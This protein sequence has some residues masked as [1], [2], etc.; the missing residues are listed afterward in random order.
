MK[1]ILLQDVAKLGHRYEVVEV[2]NGRALNML[3]PKGLAEAATENN[4]KRVKSASEKVASLRESADKEFAEIIAKLEGEA[5]TVQVKANEKGH[6]FEALKE[7][8]VAAVL[9][10]MGAAVS[11]THVLIAEPIKELGEY[12]IALSNGGDRHGVKLVVVAA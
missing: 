8:S 5:I 11:A 9:N 1:V 3:I 12:D 10:E 7:D 4:L 6:L 2:A